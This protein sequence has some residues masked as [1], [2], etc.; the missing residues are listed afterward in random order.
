MICSYTGIVELYDSS[1]R[2]IRER[3]YRTRPGRNSIIKEWEKQIGKNKFVKCI[4]HIIPDIDAS[5]YKDEMLLR[6]I[7][8]TNR[9]RIKCFPLTVNHLRL[10]GYTRVKDQIK[11]ITK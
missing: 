4:L 3:R 7:K 2:K 9:Q 8:K 10:K 1:L 5:P 11:L 6:K